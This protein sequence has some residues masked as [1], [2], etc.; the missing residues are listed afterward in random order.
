MTRTLSALLLFAVSAA[1]EGLGPSGVER[2][3]TKLL[4]VQSVHVDPLPGDGGDAIRSMLIGAV[5]RTGLFVVTE[6]PEGADAFLR[7]TA[8]DLIYTDYDR[9]RNGINVRGSASGSKREDG[10]STR[11]AGS[12]GVSDTEEATSRIRRHEATAAVRIV[13]RN[14]EVVWSTTQESKGAKY[15][16]SAADVAERIARDLA[17][18][19]KRAREIDGAAAGGG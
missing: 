19:F 12:F 9:Y 1:A 2:Q 4:G 14:G 7:G 11:S 18:A 10:E 17:D 13:L 8:E 6:N 3:W 15:M 5:Q 16:G